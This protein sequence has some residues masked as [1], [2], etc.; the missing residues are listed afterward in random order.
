MARTE[1][2]TMQVHPMEEQAAIETMQRFGWSL[3]SSQEVHVKDSHLENKLGLF[4]ESL[5]SVTET[6]HYVKLV[7]SRDLDMPN[8]DK[9]R[10]L[11]RQ[12]HGLQPEAPPPGMPGWVWAIAVV[13]SF[14]L[15]GLPLILAAVV[16]FT[17]IAPRKTEWEQQ[18]AQRAEQRRAVVQQAMQY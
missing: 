12:Y 4:G 2:K 1:S 7:F 6:T 13:S 5:V 11:E 16:H 3:L 10:E 14:F 9:L 17:M 15:F 8:I 18:S